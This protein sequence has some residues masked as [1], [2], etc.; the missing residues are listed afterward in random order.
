VVVAFV[1]AILRLSP[2]FWLSAQLISGRQCRGYPNLAL[3]S[4]IGQPI[5]FLA[6]GFAGQTIRTELFEIQKADL[7]RKAGIKGK[8]LVFPS[9]FYH[10]RQR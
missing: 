6:G 2:G 7:G 3:M 10:G 4:R 9:N 5:P 8:S 1:P